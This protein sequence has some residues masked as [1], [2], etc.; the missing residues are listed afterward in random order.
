MS[1][2]DEPRMSSTIGRHAAI[3]TRQERRFDV[4]QPLEPVRCAAA[5]GRRVV[6]YQGVVGH[7]F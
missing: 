2:R 1:A 3:K 7:F 6:L 5:G 4:V